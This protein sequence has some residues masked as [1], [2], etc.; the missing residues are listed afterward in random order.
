MLSVR[1]QLHQTPSKSHLHRSVNSNVSS[2]EQTEP[3]GRLPIIKTRQDLQ[4]VLG[5]W[6]SGLRHDLDHIE[7]DDSSTARHILVVGVVGAE[8]DVR[9]PAAQRSLRLETHAAHA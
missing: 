3:I 8:C 5:E 7:D 2:V 4:L 9:L 6:Q 1:S